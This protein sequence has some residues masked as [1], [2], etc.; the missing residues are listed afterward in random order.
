MK[1]SKTP[2]KK[3]DMASSKKQEKNMY[4]VSNIKTLFEDLINAYE[5]REKLLASLHSDAFE[6]KLLGVV[7]SGQKPLK[8]PDA[9]KKP[10]SAYLLFCAKAREDARKEDPDAKLSTQE[11]AGQWKEIKDSEEGKKYK[12]KADKLREAYKKEMEDYTPPSD[13]EL[14]SLDV[15]K[16][17]AGRKPKGSASP[18]KKKPEG[19][20]KSAKNAWNFFAAEKR[21][22][23]KAE[24]VEGREVTK[25]LGEMWK[26]LPEEEKK[27]YEKM[28]KKDKKRFEEEMKE[29]EEAHKGDEEEE[30]KEESE[31][32][33]E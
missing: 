22:E 25:R 28:V 21:E 32:E 19:Y 18:K 27:P 1:T 7:V 6:K 10:M 31:E 29:W 4:L 5:K 14:R 12:K 3:P 16:P 9:P 2:T 26:E 15:N 30:P 8:D 17:K 20:P 33:D 24:G 11:L 23:V 13:E